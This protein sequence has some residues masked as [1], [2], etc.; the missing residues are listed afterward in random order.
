VW[1]DPHDAGDVSRSQPLECDRVAA[2]A[3]MI[4]ATLQTNGARSQFVRTSPTA[5]IKVAAGGDLANCNVLSV[6]RTN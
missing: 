3:R 5:Q 6:T 4:A 2:I 1:F